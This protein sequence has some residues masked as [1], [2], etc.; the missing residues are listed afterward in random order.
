MQLTNWRRNDRRQGNPAHK[1]SDSDAVGI[2]W[3]LGEYR[4]QVT[5]SHSGGDTGFGTFLMLLLKKKMALVLMANCPW[6]GGPGSETAVDYSHA[7]SSIVRHEATPER[8]TGSPEIARFWRGSAKIGD[9]TVRNEC[10]AERT[11]YPSI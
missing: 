7:Q 6:L 11:D 2:S 3:L 4:G 1:L 5:V 9:N 8:V 10:D